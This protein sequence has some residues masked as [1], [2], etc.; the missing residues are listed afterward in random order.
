MARVSRNYFTKSHT[1]GREELLFFFVFLSF[2]L[3]FFFFFFVTYVA[4][5]ILF[6]FSSGRDVVESR[7]GLQVVIEAPKKTRGRGGK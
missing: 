7:G 2:V 6:F 1:K 3:C 5:I 4:A